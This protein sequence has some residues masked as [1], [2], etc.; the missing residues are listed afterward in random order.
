VT[1][2]PGTNCI[3]PGTGGNSIEATVDAE[4]ATAA[5][6]NA[7]IQVASCRDTSIFGGFIALQNLLNSSTPPAIVS[8]GFGM[9]EVEL[10]TANNAFVSSLYQMAVA[11]GV[12]I[13]VSSGDFGAAFGDGAIQFAV[14]GITVSGYAS[15][16]YNVSVGATDFADTYFGTNNRYW[17]ATNSP[18]FG[19]AR[20]YV[21]EIP[22]NDSCAS[23]LLATSKGFATTFGANGYCNNGG[24]NVLEA[25]SGG[26]SGCATGSPAV[27][28]VVSGTC[29]GYAKPPWQNIFG[30]PGDGV[31]DT[32]DVTLFGAVGTW[33]HYYVACFSDPG[34]GG[35]SCLGAPD[36]WAGFGGTSLSAPVMAGIQALVNQKTGSRWGNPNPIYYRLA[37]LEYGA[38]G[39]TS[40]NS[41]GSSVDSGCTFYD[42]TLGDMDVNC[43]GTHNCFFGPNP[44]T[45]GVLS[46]SNTSYQP[47][48]SAA[49][50]WD[51]ATGI[52]S[53]NAWNLI[54]N[55]SSGVS[56]GAEGLT[57]QRLR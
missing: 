28:G 21:P 56:S 29:A 50:G 48:F 57:A 53:V 6:P 24:P 47:A 38:S 41:T 23:V 31:R 9:S 49:T 40:C 4:W 46:T 35:R 1:I 45:E 22:W 52:G 25:S 33:G 27:F 30:N 13:F 43:R 17:N 51:F 19:S 36:T 5:A 32:P 8:I 34:L 39:S 7:T 12:S 3:N 26:P 2:H 14:H 37:S 18:T 54:N 42:V 15:T 16:P 44:G 55:W 20:S 11:E 10:G